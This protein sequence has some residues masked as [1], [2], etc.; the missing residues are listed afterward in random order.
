MADPRTL[1]RL[2]SELLWSLRRE[3]FA[4]APSQSLDVARAMVLLGFE[5]RGRLAD[6]VAG[7]VD[8]RSARREAYD[9]AFHAF[10]D[11]DSR[12]ELDERLAR[13][14]VTASE[15]AAV[16]EY[17]ALLV[18]AG[19]GDTTL[20]A[21]L[22]GRGELTRLLAARPTA[23]LLAGADAP[24]RAGFVAHRVLERL[25]ATRAHSDL[26]ALARD[27]RGAFGEARAAELMLLLR[28]ELARTLAEAR[29]HV[30][31][32]ARERERER[33]R[34]RGRPAGPLETPFDQLAPSE[35]AEVRLAVRRLVE[36]LRG[37]DAVRRR[38][39]ARGK[40]AAG[41]T[42]RRSFQT[43]GI[44]V[45]PVFRARVRR[46]PR[47]VV[48]CDISESVRHA[49]RFLLE[50]TYLAQSLFDD[51]RTFVFV[52]ELGETTRLF[53]ER[54]ISEA[55]AAAFGGAVV[56]IASNS[57]YGRALRAFADAELE[58]IDRR[59]TVIVLGDGRT[60]YL[61]AGADAL[62]RIAARAGAVHWL[63][64]EAR[65]AWASGDSAMETYER[66]CTR[67]LEVRTARDLDRAVRAALG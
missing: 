2:T 13:A 16:R 37:R 40:P 48:L 12:V 23:A 39:A 26:D 60:N 45:A 55:L 51:T 38:R 61:D 11:A 15:R 65:A 49:A 4:I 9:A 30:R 10:F 21:L 8:V 59:T 31:A 32:R 52:S 58:G 47:L 7:L 25:G 28:A 34:E 35:I 41:P 57:N 67:V 24:L 17:L 62:A 50:L 63:C 20:A 43:L 54:P 1:V 66:H 53:A 3:G 5:D 56:P 22:E 33:E 36:R 19:A 27:L 64:P 46:R 29:Q 44:P 6:A 14:G 42:I 18:E